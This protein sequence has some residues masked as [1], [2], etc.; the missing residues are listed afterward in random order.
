MVYKYQATPANVDDLPMFLQPYVGVDF[1]RVNTCGDGACGIHALCGQWHGSE[2]VL[3]NAR[4]VIA[5]ALGHT[6]SGI[7]NLVADA[8]VTTEL[9]DMLWNIVRQG[10]EGTPLWDENHMIWESLPMPLL[11]LSA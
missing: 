8:A 2:I 9:R 6:A 7:L 10:L 1:Q 3:A 5:E 11:P 4:Q